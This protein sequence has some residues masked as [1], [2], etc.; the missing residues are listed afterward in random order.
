MSTRSNSHSWFGAA[1]ATEVA[2]AALVLGYGAFLV[3]VVPTAAYAPVNVA[4]AGLA[5]LAVHGLG[6]SW[7]DLGL[8]RDR[9]LAGLRLG[10]LWLLPVAAGVAVAVAL[11]ATRGWFLDETIL[12]AGTAQMLYT[13]LVKIPFGTAL[14]EELI[15]RGALLGLF[16]RRHRPRVAVA[17]S[18]AL[19]GLW[20]VVSTAGRLDTNQA[21]DTA[22]GWEQVA[23]VAGAVLF[24]AAAGVFFGWL[25]LRSG[26]VLAPWLTHTGVNLLAYGG[27]RVAGRLPS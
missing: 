4:V 5:V 22:T 2:A 20:H 19:F 12:E 15:F 23:I 10:G 24:T 9:M 25:R 13:L 3:R 8:A 17:L 27:A 6:V 14:A 11:P 21:A 18:S 16:L 1:A 7:R 26:S